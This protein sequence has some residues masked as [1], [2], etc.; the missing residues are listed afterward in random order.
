MIFDTGH[1]YNN[2]TLNELFKSIFE[3]KQFYVEKKSLLISKSPKIAPRFPAT[4]PGSLA[5]S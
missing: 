1:N 3:F 5:Y 2:T 4:A